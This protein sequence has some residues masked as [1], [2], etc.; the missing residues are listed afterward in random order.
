MSVS[1]I[2]EPG[3]T[4]VT[5]SLVAR[6]G[7]G[8]PETSYPA[9]EIRPTVYATGTITGLSG[10]FEALFRNGA[11]EPIY[12]GYVNFNG[13]SELRCYDAPPTTAI[14]TSISVIPLQATGPKRQLPN[15]IPLFVGERVLTPVPVVDPAGQPV[16]L[17]GRSLLFK[18]E[19]QQRLSVMSVTP[20]V[21][22]STFSFTPTAPVTS[23]ARTLLWSLW[24]TTA[25]AVL[26]NGEIQ[27]SYVPQ[28]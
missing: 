19:T 9:T 28:R 21:S 20:N 11:N 22:G 13:D 7:S 4:G 17:A 25:E 3:E 16:V 15:I 27:I 10:E 23:I 14:A 6:G 2:G 1:M 24:D 5:L 8:T 26:C 18:V 12:S